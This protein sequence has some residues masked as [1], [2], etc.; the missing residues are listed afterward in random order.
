MS[1]IH[2]SCILYPAFQPQRKLVSVVVTIGIKALPIRPRTGRHISVVR[3][4]APY[5][6]SPGSSPEFVPL[7]CG[8]CSVSS[9]TSGIFCRN[10]F[11]Y[12]IVTFH[13]HP[14]SSFEELSYSKLGYVCTWAVIKYIKSINS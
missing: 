6:V 8:R 12:A 9:V 2:L 11:R 10:S 7:E 1:V 5:H 4:L 13:I 14:S 3:I